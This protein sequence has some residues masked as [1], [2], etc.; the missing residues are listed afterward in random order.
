MGEKD[1][2]A[3]ESC[4]TV[5]EEP[6][7][8]DPFMNPRE[9]LA[10]PKLLLHSCCGPCSTAVIERLVGDYDVTVFYYN[11]CITDEEEYIHRRET[12]IQFIEKFNREGISPVPVLFLE[13]K[14]NPQAYYEK[15]EGHEVDPEGGQRCLLCFE[16]RL[17][18]TAKHAA[19][20]GFDFFATTLSVSPHK[21]YQALSLLGQSLSETY[22]VPFLD[23][24][25]KK[26][27]GF[28]RSVQLSRQYELYRQDYCGCE[29]SK[30]RD[31]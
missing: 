1:Q 13:G 18:E 8:F 17:R 12:Q 5:L 21:D 24:D 10:R 20:G 31:E 4:L 7:V 19:G 22:R 6:A 23:I 30:R 3:P 16:M 15:T 28:Q 11:P 14:Y 25:F 29:Y 2:L 27:A 26:K 9:K